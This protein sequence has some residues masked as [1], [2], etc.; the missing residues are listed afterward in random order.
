M[1]STMP[2]HTQETTT[3]EAKNVAL[4]ISV[5]LLAA[6]IGALH[7]LRPLGDNAGSYFADLTALRFG[8]AGVAT[9]PLLLQAIFRRR[10]P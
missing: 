4:G 10:E 5:G 3:A 2:I 9:L 6:S 8:V 1:Q 7:R